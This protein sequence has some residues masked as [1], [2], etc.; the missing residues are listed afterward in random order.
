MHV[1]ASPSV[2]AT[3]GPGGVVVCPDIGGA[4]EPTDEARTE[5][6]LRLRS[7]GQPVRLGNVQVQAATNFDIAPG[8]SRRCGE[9]TIQLSRWVHVCTTDQSRCDVNTDSAPGLAADYLMLKTGKEWH[10][11]YWLPGGDPNPVP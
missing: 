2:T 3:S 9:R 10:A 1:E 7:A 11:W 5:I 8:L 4:V 6:V